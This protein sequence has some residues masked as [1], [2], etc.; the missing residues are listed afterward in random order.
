M[1]GGLSILWHYCQVRRNL[2]RWNDRSSL[3]AWQNQIVE[4]HLTRVLPRSA[5]YRQLYRDRTLSDWREFPIIT[6]AE[7]MEHFDD[8]NTVGVRREHAFKVATDAEGSRDFLPMIGD[9]T[10]G[11]SS[12]TSGNRG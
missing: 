2:H 8:L 11:L 10:V 5:F 12:G 6:K 7:M 3:E 4:Q 1:S 9:V